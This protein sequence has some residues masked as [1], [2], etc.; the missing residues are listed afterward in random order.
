MDSG[1]VDMYV[2]I[3]EFVTDTAKVVTKEETLA[4][5]I[6]ADKAAKRTKKELEDSGNTIV[7]YSIC[8]K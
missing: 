3:L 8:R 6:D 1:V 7:R 5:L 2:Y 4:S